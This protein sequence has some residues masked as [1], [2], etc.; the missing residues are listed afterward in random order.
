M[1]QTKV[2]THL[3]NNVLP[4]AVTILRDHWLGRKAPSVTLTMRPRRVISNHQTCTSFNKVMARESANRLCRLGFSPLSLKGFGAASITGKTQ[5]WAKELL[6]REV[7]VLT[8]SLEVN[9]T[10]SVA[11]LYGKVEVCVCHINNHAVAFFM[12]QQTR[13]EKTFCDVLHGRVNCRS[14]V[15]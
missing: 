5:T 14:H 10:F 11:T 1:S 8:N 6:R 3:A 2:V 9:V 7:P 15:S 4:Y 12:H 13:Y